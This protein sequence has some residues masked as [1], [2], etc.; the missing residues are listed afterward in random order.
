MKLYNKIAYGFWLACYSVC[1]VGVADAADLGVAAGQPG[2]TSYAMV[3]DV[4]RVCPNPHINVLQSEGSL[5]NI[6]RISGDK[7]V[8]FGYSQEDAL[9]YQQ[10]LDPDMM[11]H[12]YMVFPLY[13]AELHLV[14]AQNSNIHSLPDLAGKRVVESEQ[15]AGTWVT[16]QV[17][18]QATGIKWTPLYLSKKDSITALQNGSA[19]AAFFVEGRPIDA[20]QNARGLRLIP[21]ADSRL[22]GFKYYTKTL[23]PSNTYPGQTTSVQTYKINIGLMTYAYKNQYQKEIGGLVSCIMRNMSTLQQTGHPKWKNVDPTDL[24]RIQWQVHPAALAAI[25]GK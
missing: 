17:V 7:A 13:A 18:K 2:S 25:H 16:A 5:D 4:A 11:K 3:S 24:D 23:I 20:L 14:V 19:D 10:G 15:G 6:A 8:Q 12:I 1:A 9:I 21:V 22:D